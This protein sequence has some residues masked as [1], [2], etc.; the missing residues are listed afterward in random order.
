MI[1]FSK[2]AKLVKQYWIIAAILLIASFF[3][4]YDISGYMEFLGDQ[5]R[6]VVIVRRFLTQGDLMFIG[7]QTSVGNMYL[8]PWYYYF[9]APSLLAAN[10][11]P[12]GPSVMVALVGIAAIWLVWFVAREW[13][14]KKAAIISAFL[15]AISPVVIKYSSFSWNPNIIPFF[16]LLSVWLVW[17]VWEKNEYKKLPLLG[18]CLGM[19]MAS[20][21]LGLLIFP[22]VFLLILLA[23]RKTAGDIGKRNFK[24][25]GL[26]GL[27]I[28]VAMIL[29]LALFDIKHNGSNLKALTFLLKG[30]SSVIAF[31][32]IKYLF[33]LFFIFKQI[34][35]RL[36][37][38]KNELA[39]GLLSIVLFF[40]AIQL[41]ILNRKKT[42]PRSRCFSLL[43][44]WI[45]LGICGLGLYR[46]ELID[47]Y[48]GFL[49]PAWFI[50]FGLMVSFL[51]DRKKYLRIIG[52]VLLSASII[53]SA[54]ENPL[55]FPA[56]NQL[57][58]TKRVVD[59]II[60]QSDGKSFNLA[61]L[62]KRNYDPPYRYYFDL[63]NAPLKNL[64]DEL[65]DQLFV[66][67]EDL[68]EECKP[69]G[70]SFWDVAA[71]GM[72]RTEQGWLFG[73]VE[74]YKLVHSQ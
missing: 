9:I 36:L 35:T 29:P 20:H 13:F 19:I 58:S 37:A 55:R 12:V 44:A 67:C 31:S 14:G 32:P 71:F 68:D 56:N 6:D 26:L 51:I 23:F 18:F 39:G 53:F 38:G 48:F 4:L 72:A 33:S 30:D 34:T 5:G 28:F 11:S 59:F 49:F 41:Y 21:Y 74:I 15:Y 22:M 2:I 10:F 57:S 66:I 16:S 45:L 27:G 17:R 69:L 8:G 43:M 54:I 46:H 47:H 52:L 3:R 7:P 61:L 24:S 1:Y 25:S 40:S 70:N 62:A 63:K 65:T 64:H 73:N 50:L 42:T 60:S